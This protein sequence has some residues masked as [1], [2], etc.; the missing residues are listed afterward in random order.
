ML[1]WSRLLKAMAK[2]AGQGR[3]G[4]PHF[5][6][7]PIVLQVTHLA[8]PAMFIRPRCISG[9]VGVGYA[10]SYSYRFGVRRGVNTA[11]LNSRR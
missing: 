8:V 4:P 3:G 6:Q 1:E 2:D 10:K 9:R 7:K 11:A 5:S